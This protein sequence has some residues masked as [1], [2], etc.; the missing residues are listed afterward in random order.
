MKKTKSLTFV[1]AMLF[2]AACSKPNSAAFSSSK[3]LSSKEEGSLTAHVDPPIPSSNESS[4]TLSAEPSS[5]FESSSSSSSSSSSEI[6]EDKSYYN[7]Y[8]DTLVSWTNGEDLKN[9][10][11]TIMRNGYTPLSYV[12]SS[13]A[14]WLTNSNADHSKYDFEILDVIY[15]GDDVS[16]NDTNKSW[17]REHAFCASLMTGSTTG[18]A[19]KYKG[20]AT[21][22][23]NLIAASTNG[24]TSRGNKNY[25]YTN[26]ISA[27]FTDR[28]I[29]NGYDGYSYDETIFEPANKDKG[30]LARA[31]FYMATM[32]KDDEQDTANN[33]LMKGLKIVEDPVSYVQGNNC[34]FAIGNL[35]DLL[36]WNDRFAVDYL[37]MQHN[38]SVY[39]DTDN[40]DGVAQGN[41]NPYVDYPGLVDYVYGDKKN[42]PGTLKDVIASASYLGS[43]E[44]GVSHYAIKEAKRDYSYGDTLTSNDYKVVTVNKNYTT[45]VVTSGISNSLNNHTFVESDGKS[46]IATVT[47]P[48]NELSYVVSLDPI[49][50]TSSGEIFLNVG[51]LDK[52]KPGVAQEITCGGVDLLVTYESSAATPITI[53]NISSP[54][55]ITFGSGTK[56]VSGVTIKTKNNVTVDSAYIKAFA[57]NKSSS[58]QLTI[59]VGDIVLLNP[60]T[61]NSTDAQVFGKK[62]TAACTG[63]LTF[64]FTGNTSLKINSIAFNE[65][66]V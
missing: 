46:L 31:I 27:S 38:I 48:S 1:L 47:T 7:G 53:Q 16:K 39:T 35:S 63:Q 41:S 34:A 19:V 37:E 44:K 52:N 6:I 57:G 2:V 24:N 59:K 13:T 56:A 28:T 8:Y 45:S 65:V 61:V 4:S 62:L 15:S 17:Q 26:A 30:R 58:Y 66:S 29:N 3:K 23:H 33:I 11:Y 40:L 20:R 22:F 25:G 43:E 21:D 5:S 14:N 54:G 10:L 50:Q 51:S 9:Q 42:Q 55:G 60:T 18:N 64:I 49:G 12:K 36:E 32:Y